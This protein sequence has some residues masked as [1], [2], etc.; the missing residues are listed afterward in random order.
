MLNKKGFTILEMAA[1]IVI[2]IPLVFGMI[3]VP[4]SLYVDYKEYSKV[5]TYN[6]EMNALKNSIIHDSRVSTIKE[7][8]GNEI[9]IGNHS[10]NFSNKGVYRDGVQVASENTSFKVEEQVLKIKTKSST[11]QFPIAA[12]SLRE[13][14]LNEQ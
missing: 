9:S 13:V 10:Y 5:V 4:V 14:K 1:A 3:Y 2:S 7:I 6:S 8:N 11:L 12:K